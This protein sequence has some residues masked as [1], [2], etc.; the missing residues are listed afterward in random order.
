MNPIGLL[1]MPLFPHLENALNP[2]KC[3]KSVKA[4]RN[5]QVVQVWE[6]EGA[7][8]LLHPSQGEVTR[9]CQQVRPMVSSHIHE[10][11]RNAPMLFVPHSLPC[12]VVAQGLL[13]PSMQCERS[14]LHW[15]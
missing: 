3:F 5:T 2:S 13:G 1:C 6:F 10:C 12:R 9:R 4:S 15:L 8:G 7:L 14:P 11:I